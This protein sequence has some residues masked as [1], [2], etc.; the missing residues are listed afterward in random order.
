MSAAKVVK[1]DAAMER[2][3]EI[4]MNGFVTGVSSALSTFAPS[5]PG[6]MCDA[7]ADDMA[8]AL[9]KDRLSMEEVVNQVRETLAGVDSGPFAF[10]LGR[11]GDQ[12]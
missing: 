8:A 12:S 6:D 3:V 1:G 11:L 5:L 9:R 4:Y 2:L 7:A 10:T